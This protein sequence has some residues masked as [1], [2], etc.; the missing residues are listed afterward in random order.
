MVARI[1]ITTETMDVMTAGR[2]LKIPWAMFV[3]ISK[4]FCIICGMLVIK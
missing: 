1:C 3:T 2:L 4:P